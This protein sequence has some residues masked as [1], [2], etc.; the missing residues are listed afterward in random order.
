[1]LRFMKAFLCH[2]NRTAP[3]NLLS[4]FRD[5]GISL[6]LK[7]ILLFP[8][9]TLFQER[10][11]IVNK[12]LFAIS[13][14]V[15]F[16]SVRFTKKA[17]FYLLGVTALWVYS[18]CVTP[19]AAL[20][21]NLNMAI[22]YVFLVFYF[23]F[24]LEYKDRIWDILRQNKR[25]IL[26]S[27]LVYTAILTVTIFLPISYSASSVGGWGDGIYFRSI[28]GS[29]NR[30]GPA[31]VFAVVMIILLLM[32][33]CHK[34]IALAALPQLYVFFMGGSR[35]YFVVGL[36]TALVLVYVLINNR[37]I[38]FLSLIP[39]CI[40]AFLL[41]SQS[42]MMDKLLA[43]FKPGT[44][45][46]VFWQKLTNTRSIFWVKQLELFFDTPLLM[47]IFG[48]GINFTTHQYG[49]WAHSDFI[50]ILCSYG[51][52]GLINYLILMCYTLRVF[53]FKNKQHLFIKLV[54]VF[55]WFFNA[56]FNFFYCYFCAMLCYPL[57]L[58]A[59]HCFSTTTKATPATQDRLE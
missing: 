56:F 44:S 31:S 3:F 19:W 59:M 29:P 48:N 58:L 17:F 41:V 55:I 25:Y 35:T 40:A 32:L 24:F 50:E 54:C 33:N 21:L 43:T 39:L 30:V 52:L 23:V 2:N 6:F 46:L 12:A 36:C 1:V 42:S 5:H 4:F 10:V 51:Y 28:S 34:L 9:T 38:F 20:K 26:I 47:Q 16:L 13:L 57:L 53:L 7:L 8:I 14:I 18:L 49:L 37:K 45:P 11:D 22:Y 15:F 27:T